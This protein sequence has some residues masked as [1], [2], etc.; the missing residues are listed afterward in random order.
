MVRRPP[1]YTRTDTRFPYTTLFRS[2]LSEQWKK[3][4][5][6]SFIVDVTP[7]HDQDDVITGFLEVFKYAVKFSDL[8]LADNRSEEQ[9]YELQPLM[10]ISYAHLCL[11]K[12]TTPKHTT[13]ITSYTIKYKQPTQQNY[14]K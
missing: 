12:K 10:R 9:T 3:I 7:F 5:G 2:A 1:R 14:T 8:P 6:D 4:T 11:Q 13:Y